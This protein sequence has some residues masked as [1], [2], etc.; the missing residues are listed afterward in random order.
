VFEWRRKPQILA[1]RRRKKTQ[2]EIQMA[3]SAGVISFGGTS[4][5]SGPVIQFLCPLDILLGW[6]S[7]LRAEPFAIICELFASICG[8]LFCQAS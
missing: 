8:L 6:A 7:R 4:L 1:N 2:I 5:L 3:W